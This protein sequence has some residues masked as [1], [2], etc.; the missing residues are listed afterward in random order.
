I[1]EVGSEPGSTLE[2]LASAAEGSTR[3]QA[4]KPAGFT[5][6]HSILEATEK[7]CHFDPRSAIVGV[8]L[9]E[10]DEAPVAGCVAVEEDGV[11]RAQQEVLEH[12]VIGKQDVGWPLLHLLAAQKLV[13]QGLD[14]WE[15]LAET[16]Q[17]RLTRLL[18]LAD[19][20]TEGDVWRG[21]QQV[22]Q[23]LDLVIGQSVHRVEEKCADAGLAQRSGLAL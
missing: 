19:V 11:R 21:G 8:R 20:A 9:I 17:R 1:K 12:R 18:R 15:L 14:P 10:H 16:V 22:T 6:D 5:L 4:L 7:H 13:R 2:V 23:P 3:C